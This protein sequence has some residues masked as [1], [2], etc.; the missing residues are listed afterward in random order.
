[1]NKNIRFFVFVLVIFSGVYNTAMGAEKVG[2]TSFQFLKIAPDAR[3]SAMGGAFVSVVNTS[4]AVFWNPGA[5]AGITGLDISG[6]YVDYFVDVSISSFSAAIPL[7]RLGTVGFQ[8]SILD[9]GSIEV[10]EVASQG[11]NSDYTRFNPGLTGE[12]IN[13]GSMVFGLSFARSLTDKFNFGLTAKYVTEDLVREKASA[14][15]FDGGLTYRT[16]F[17]SLIL[18]AAVRNFGP[19]IKF[20]NESYPLPQTFT[21]GISG[22]LISSENSLVAQS[23]W[24]KLLFSYDI[25]HPRDYDQ[26]HTVGVEYTFKNMLI[27]RGGYKFNYD[28]EGIAFGMGLKIKN[29]RLDYAYDPF[30]EILNSIHK[31]TVGYGLK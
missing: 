30:G 5:L 16:G 9:Y 14:L 18:G 11:W 31:V 17:R 23:P 24:Q 12:T 19:E 27:L 4:E 15:V 7:F 26:Q 2:T 8:A 22:Y 28:E 29:I 21:F 1:M 10:T 25:V 6:S 13:P 3:S 20:I